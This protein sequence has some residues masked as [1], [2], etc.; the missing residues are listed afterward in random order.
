[1]LRHLPLTINRSTLQKDIA[2]AKAALGLTGKVTFHDMRHSA[3]SEMI[4][5]GVDLFTVGQ[6]LGHRDP[7]STKRY[8]HLTAE[9]L[10]GA[11]NLIGK[12]RAA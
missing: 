3:A 8:S 1:M 9:R 6:V 11:V 12:K 10:A 2:R 7:R 4:N 5:A